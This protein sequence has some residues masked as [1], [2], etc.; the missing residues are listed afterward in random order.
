METLTDYLSIIPDEAQKLRM[1]EVFDWIQVNYPML[2]SEI[3]WNQ[4][5]F[6]DHGTFI[7][8]FSMAKHHMAFTPEDVGIT[9]FKD[10]IDAAGYAHTKGIVKVKWTEEVDYKL[11]KTMIDFNI[12]DKK[13]CTTFFRK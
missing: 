12:A 1:E 2:T 3:K 5:M 8:G 4:P 13:S 6:I 7:I 10:M 11:I 9:Q